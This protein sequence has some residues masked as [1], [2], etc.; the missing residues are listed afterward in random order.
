MK[1]HVVYDHI[2][3][4]SDIHFAN[5]F[6][7]ELNHIFIATQVL[8]MVFQLGNMVPKFDFSSYPKAL[9]TAWFIM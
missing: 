5:N 7:P 6:I 8:Y 9:E 3:E 2:L 1:S 4:N